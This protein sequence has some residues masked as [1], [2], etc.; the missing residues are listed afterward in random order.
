MANTADTLAALKE[1]GGLAKAMEMAQKIDNRLSYA[2]FYGLP[3]HEQEQAMAART[4]IDE[5]WDEYQDLRKQ[6]TTS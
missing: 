6:D 1:S 2:N 4:F 3:K 5:H